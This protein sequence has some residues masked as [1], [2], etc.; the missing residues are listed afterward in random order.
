VTVD[1]VIRGS[2]LIAADVI[3]DHRPDEA[4]PPSECLLC[5]VARRAALGAI[6]KLAAPARTP[7]AGPASPRAVIIVFLV[8][9]PASPRAAVAQVTS[10]TGRPV[11]V[12]PL[13]PPAAARA[14][15]LDTLINLVV[16]HDL[17]DVGLFL[18]GRCFLF[19]RHALRH[20][21]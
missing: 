11:V 3:D 16:F 21:F 15:S 2:T 9:I 6:S 12:V 8:V 10:A 7:A 20:R 19:G 5:R 1:A 4:A 17:G 14:T 13:I 18:L